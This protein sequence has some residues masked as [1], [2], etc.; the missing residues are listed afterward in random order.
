M[1]GES[2]EYTGVSFFNAI[3]NEAFNRNSQVRKDWM[4]EYLD[5]GINVL[6]VWCQWDNNRGFV[7]GGEGKT[8]FEDDGTIKPEQLE[9]IK[10]IIKDADAKEMIILLVLFSRESWNQNLRLSDQA[11]DNSMAILTKELKPFGNVVFQIWNEFD[12]RTVDYYKIVKSVDPQRLVTNSPG[13]AGFLGSVKENITL[14]Y[15]S[16]HTSRK[17][18]RHWEI[19]PKEIAYLIEKYKKPV[20]DDEPARRGTPK[21]GGPTSV[22]YPQDHILRIYNVWKVGGYVIYHHDMFQTGYGTDAVPPNGIPAPGFS[23]YHDEVYDFLKN[24]ERVL[25]Q[26]K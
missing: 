5:V 25:I 2:F 13:Y 6:R 7:D 26:I 23:N 16:P 18:N 4:Q 11:S 17:T 24:K 3:F 15:L 19:A 22:N 20:V 10:S 8:I 12:Y 21:F 14:D 1:N 9:R